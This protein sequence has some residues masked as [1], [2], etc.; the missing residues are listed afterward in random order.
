ML[1][2]NHDCRQKI[3]DRKYN[4]E[5]NKGKIKK[6][7]TADKNKV[8]RVR[9]FSKVLRRITQYDKISQNKNKI[10]EAPFQMSNKNMRE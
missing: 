6:I 1:E 2:K 3:L 5:N 4:V 9:Y 7:I 10:Y 8:Q